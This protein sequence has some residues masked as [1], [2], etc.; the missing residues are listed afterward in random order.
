MNLDYYATLAQQ[1]GTQKLQDIDIEDIDKA[2]TFYLLTAPTDKNDGNLFQNRWAKNQRTVQMNPLP[3]FI[4]A[5]S[6]DLAQIPIGAFFIQFT[7]KLVKPYISKG[8]NTFYI[9]DNP[10]V[11]DKVFRYPVVHST[12]WKGALHHV[13]WQLGYQDN[14]KIQ[15]LFGTANDDEPNEGK[16]GRFYFYPTFF[17]QTSLEIVNPHDRKRRFGKNPILFESVP[18]GA[19][20]TFSLLYIPFDLIG[21]PES[22]IRTSVI[23]DLCLITQA[24]HALFTT[25]GFGAKT[26]SGFGL[27]QDAVESGQLSI[28]LSEA[29]FS[30]NAS[31]HIQKPED[32]FI[33]YLDAN[34]QI[35][36]AFAGS[37]ESGLMSNSEY[38]QTGAQHGGGSLSEFK[39]FRSW[40]TQHGEQWQK[41]M[42]RSAAPAAYPNTTFESLSQ[43]VQVCQNL[44]SN[45]TNGG[46]A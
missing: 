24:L 29:T 36:P 15:R 41:N 31:Q 26:S 16:A 18:A 22:Q 33:K 30:Q 17:T 34:G 23:A 1:V 13:L 25:Y 43:L 37:G 19:R 5:V 38:K 8:D 20:G 39:Q 44:T 2:T 3:E 6:I 14:E 28:K 32:T 11:R 40:Y 21:Q 35:N 12:A 42:Q 45:P 9:I 46:A 7:F 27:A 4:Q 10:I